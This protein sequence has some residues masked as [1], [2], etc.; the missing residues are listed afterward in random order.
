MI[1]VV[2]VEIVPRVVP[3]QTFIP[4][5]GLVCKNLRLS[6]RRCRETCF[7]MPPRL[8]ASLLASMYEWKHGLIESEKMMLV[9]ASKCARTHSRTM[10]AG[11]GP[12]RASVNGVHYIEVYCICADLCQ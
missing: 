6:S 2:V 9:I 3:N 10:V 1:V 5:E 11:G 12:S 7:L 4:G 8:I